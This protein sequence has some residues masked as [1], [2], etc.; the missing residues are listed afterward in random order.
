MKDSSIPWCDHTFNPWEG[1]TEM[2]P[3][4]DNC[5][6]AAR[7]GRFHDGV[8][9]G[10]NSPRLHHTDTYWRQPITWNR[11]DC[12]ANQRRRVFCGSL[13]D[14]MEDRRD[15]DRDRERL[16]RLIE[17]TP[18]LDWLLLTKRPM[19]YRRLLPAR[20]L[21]QPQPNVWL[22]TTVE[23]QEYLW[24]IDE[25]ARVPAVVYGV[26]FE[27]LLGPITLGHYAHAIDW[28]IIGGESGNGARPFDLDWARMLIA[29]CRAAGNVAVYMKQVGA[30]PRD[31]LVH[32]RLKDPKGGKPHEWPDL[33]IREFPTPTTQS[34]ALQ[35]IGEDRLKP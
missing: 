5:Y 14:V 1:C 25:L 10:K 2:S 9:W 11:E 27:P 17:S 35:R 19:N 8:H 18:C 20:W 29:E 15:L 21:D 3:G 16:F 24:R 6:A 30:S 34:E 32:I 23:S 4:C 33:W 7:D 31:G 13:C 12:R 28:A 22:L 26:S